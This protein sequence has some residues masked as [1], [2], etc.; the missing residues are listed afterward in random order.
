MDQ[1]FTPY[2]RYGQRTSLARSMFF[3]FVVLRCEAAAWVGVWTYLLVG[4][5]ADGWDSLDDR[6]KHRVNDST[7]PLN[8]PSG[9]RVGFVSICAS[10]PLLSRSLSLLFGMFYTSVVKSR[11]SGTKRVRVS[12]S[13]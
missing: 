6:L 3:V 2:H 9:E 10:L 13:R 12:R 8:K 5:S 7:D 1:L 4:N 11:G